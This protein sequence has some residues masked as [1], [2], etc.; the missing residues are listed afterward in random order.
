LYG[1]VT[2]LIVGT[3][4]G[5]VW[6]PIMAK[7]GKEPLSYM[8]TLAIVFLLYASSEAI[9]SHGVVTVL[10]FGLVLANTEWIKAHVLPFLNTWTSMRTASVP[11]DVDGSLSR[12]NS[13]LSFLVRTFFF[14]YVGMIVD[15]TSFDTITVIGGVSIVV[16]MAVMR[17]LSVRL[18]MR[19]RAMVQGR[20]LLVISLLPRGLASIVMVLTAAA[21]NIPGLAAM[22]QLVFLVVLLSNLGMTG[23]LIADASGRS[24]REPVPSST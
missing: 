20:E 19:G 22:T 15:F 24:N 12:M 1:V 18:V 21:A 5:L 7:Y 10:Q 4:S 6:I 2:A 16:G 13:E 9:H 14:V 8:V 11:I 3:A 23:F 17:W